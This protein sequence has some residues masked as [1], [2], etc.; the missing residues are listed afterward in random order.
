MADVVYTSFAHCREDDIEMKPCLAYN[1]NRPQSIID[2]TVTSTAAGY[3]MTVVSSDHGSEAR[4][5]TSTTQLILQEDIEAPSE[6]EKK[7]QDPVEY[8]TVSKPDVQK[9]SPT[10]KSTGEAVYAEV[11]K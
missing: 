9:C 10:F 7:L 11:E 3:Y 4:H 1:A 5:C 6:A 8:S 2:T